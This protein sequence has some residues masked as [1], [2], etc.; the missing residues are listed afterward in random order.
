MP[1]DPDKRQHK[2]ETAGFRV[3]GDYS[4]AIPA[5]PE[6]DSTTKYD[7]AFYQARRDQNDRLVGLSVQPI[8][9]PG[10]N[11][12]PQP[13]AGSVAIAFAYSTFTDKT[14]I[15]P[16]FKGVDKFFWLDN[17]GSITEDPAKT[18]DFVLD[19][20]EIILHDGIAYWT[21]NPANFYFF[22]DNDENSGW[23][24]ETFEFLPWTNTTNL[25]NSAFFG[26]GVRMANPNIVE[27][28]NYLDVTNWTSL[29]NFFYNS[30]SKIDYSGMT[31]WDISNVTNI[32]NLFKDPNPSIPDFS[33]WNYTNVTIA[34]YVF[35]TMYDGVPRWI[36]RIQWGPNLVDMASMGGTNFSPVGVDICGDG[37]PLDLSGWCVTNIT[38]APTNFFQTSS[39]GGTDFTNVIMPVWGTCP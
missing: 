21:E 31:G 8:I 28:L 25:V 36:E 6:Y 20:D 26:A 27:Q 14:S 38:S 2:I 35:S 34:S 23:Q 24:S 17:D 11:P 33:H 5:H 1:F 16:Q 15:I 13:P 22:S 39:G 7:N 12:I 4:H 30:R 10:D 18:G 19:R 37:N 9:Y 3:D 29:Q 32:T